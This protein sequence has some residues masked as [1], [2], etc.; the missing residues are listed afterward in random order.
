[1]CATTN[2]FHPGACI[3]SLMYPRSKMNTTT[4]EFAFGAH[5]TPQR[6]LSL[7]RHVATNHPTRRYFTATILALRS[8]H[9]ATFETGLEPSCCSF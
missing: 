3:S 6:H 4:T 5:V 8:T 9:S 7:S 2:Q 1:M